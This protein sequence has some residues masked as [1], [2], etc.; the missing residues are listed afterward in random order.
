MN[1]FAESAAYIWEIPIV[2]EHQDLHVHFPF[3]LMTQPDHLAQEL[4]HWAWRSG[5]WLAE[6]E[7]EGREAS[8]ALRG[9]FVGDEPGSFGL[10]G[11]RGRMAS[12]DHANEQRAWELL[13]CLH[14]RMRL[15]GHGALL[16]LYP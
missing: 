11:V 4:S 3:R 1:I 7:W 8:P 5:L 2:K 16:M 9:G 15:I 13:V 12:Q 6:A 10:V 14:C